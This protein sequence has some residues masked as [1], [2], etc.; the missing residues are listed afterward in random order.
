MDSGMDEGFAKLI[1][2]LENELDET[3]RLGVSLGKITGRDDERREKTESADSAS[4]RNNSRLHRSLRRVRDLVEAVLALPEP[5][6]ATPPGLDYALHRL[7]DI[8]CSLGQVDEAASYVGDLRRLLKSPDSV[9]EL[10]HDYAALV[11][12]HI[13]RDEIDKACLAHGLLLDLTADDD[14]LQTLAY[15]TFNL[16]NKLITASRMK[17]AQ[18]IYEKMRALVAREPELSVVRQDARPPAPTEAAG[19]P[20]DDPPEGRPAPAPPERRPV[21]TLVEAGP[22]PGSKPAAR[23]P[24]VVTDSC[25]RTDFSI[26]IAQ[27]SVNIISGYSSTNNSDKADAVFRRMPDPRGDPE[28]MILKIMAGTNLIQVYLQ[29]NKWAKAHEVFKEVRELSLESDNNTFV[30]KGAVEMIGMARRKNL[31]DAEAIYASLAG[32]DNSEEFQRERS[33][34]CGNLVFVLGNYKQYQ[35]AREHLD[36]MAEFGTSPRIL[37]IR[38]KAIINLLSDFGANNMAAESEEL[39]GVLSNLAAVPYMKSDARPYV[40]AS[41]IRATHILMVTHINQ[42]NFGRAQSLFERML[43]LAGQDRRAQEVVSVSAFSLVTGYVSTHQI[44]RAMEIF[45]VFDRLPKTRL[46]MVEKGKSQ[47]NLAYHIGNQGLMTMARK[48]FDNFVKEVVEFEKNPADADEKD[49][50]LAYVDA[51]SDPAFLPGDDDDEL[52]EFAEGQSEGPNDGYCDDPFLEIIEGLGG[53]YADDERN[54]LHGLL[55]KTAF[56]LVA[57][58]L[59]LGRFKEASSVY[60]TILEFKDRPG[61]VTDLIHTA[62]RLISSASFYDKWGMVM[63]VFDTLGDL[64]DLPAANEE[65][66]KAA[67]AILNYMPNK[68]LADVAKLYDFIDG[69]NPRENF[70]VHL[71]RAAMEMVQFLV[72]AKKYREAQEMYNKMADMGASLKTKERQAIAATYLM[73]GYASLGWLGEAKKLYESMPETRRNNKVAKY[74]LQAGKMLARMMKKSG[75]IESANELDEELG[76]YKALKEA[77]RKSDEED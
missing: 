57:D 53:S 10:S 23:P 18:D 58:Y 4:L 51:Y 14:M 48:V 20:G 35:K 65:K 71:A 42:K 44:D 34:A 31:D 41:L 6:D 74:R 67:V 22:A 16:V 32:L 45:R 49:G 73:Q 72:K 52:Y 54:D 70:G 38:C 5:S 62:L 3:Q 76:G 7:T 43:S 26:F 63:D 36:S 59:D 19:E 60:R 46:T 69:L 39:Y 28:Y 77:A 68:K 61:A 11:Q 27:I 21:L 9:W 33:K 12:G 2:D 64:P 24:V 50:G 25:S 37:K 47:V 55:A 66:C 17:E 75:L 29:D 1:A 15:A 8:L 30:A 40:Q 13:E 56:N